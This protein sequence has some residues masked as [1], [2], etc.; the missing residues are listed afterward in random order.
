MLAPTSPPPMSM[1]ED[2]VLRAQIAD[3]QAEAALLATQFSNLHLGT[4]NHCMFDA[5]QA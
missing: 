3:E 4:V 5:P 1:H 2:P